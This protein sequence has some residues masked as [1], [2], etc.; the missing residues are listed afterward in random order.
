MSNQYSKIM[1]GD[2][3]KDR[4]DGRVGTFNSWRVLGGVQCGLLI[5]GKARWWV[6]AV[7]LVKTLSAKQIAVKKRRLRLQQS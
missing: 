7:F 5:A 1:L 3:V 6:P 4:R 2:T